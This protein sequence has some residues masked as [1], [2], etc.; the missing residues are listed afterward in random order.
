MAGAQVQAV[1]HP[2]QVLL[3]HSR[4]H[5]DTGPPRPLDVAAHLIGVQRRE[6]LRLGTRQ[7]QPVG[8]VGAV[9]VGA[10]AGQ[11]RAYL[12]PVDP[13]GPTCTVQP[14]VEVLGSVAGGERRAFVGEGQRHPP[15]AAGAAPDLHDRKAGEHPAGAIFDGQAESAEAVALGE[16][17]RPGGMVERE[18]ARI[19]GHECRPARVMDRAEENL[20]VHAAAFL[21][22]LVASL[23][24]RVPVMS[25]GR[26]GRTGQHLVHG[27]E[28]PT[29]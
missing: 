1:E 21:H 14:T 26:P 3:D 2:G 29:W 8:Q 13:V 9:G 18:R 19:P 24:A 7:R 15:R 22:P 16:H 10:G 28:Y 4:T 17:R 20:D 6:D 12:Q 27:T 25:L 5:G 11:L 23:P